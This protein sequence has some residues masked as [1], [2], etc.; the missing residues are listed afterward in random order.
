LWF[1]FYNEI[2]LSYAKF[3]VNLISIYKVTSC[4][5]LTRFL[6]YPINYI[7]TK[8]KRVAWKTSLFILVDWNGLTTA[9]FGSV[10]DM[11]THK[12]CQPSCGP[13][14]PAFLVIVHQN[15]PTVMVRVTLFNRR[16]RGKIK[17]KKMRPHILRICPDTHLRSICTYFGLLVLLMGVI[18]CAKFYRNRL[19][20]LAFVG[21]E[22]WPL[23]KQWGVAINRGHELLFTLW[24]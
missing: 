7:L 22:F 16:I 9:L 2:T 24:G 11:W 19:R 6:A 14:K 5:T 10:Y 13:P 4:K 12:C 20:G 17:I 18:S 15:P 8:G 21:V 1:H 23:L 3:S